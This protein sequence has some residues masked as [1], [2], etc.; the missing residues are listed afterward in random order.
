MTTSLL[1]GSLQHVLD[2]PDRAEDEDALLVPTLYRRHR[3]RGADRED[4]TVV[5]DPLVVGALDLLLF[6]VHLLKMHTAP[7]SYV[8]LLVPPIGAHAEVLMKIYRSCHVLRETY[9]V[10]GPDLLVAI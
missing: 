5:L 2:V 4:Q 10:V 6:G 9:P 1:R 3:G 8:A 7:E